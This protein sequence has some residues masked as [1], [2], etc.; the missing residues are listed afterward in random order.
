[1][2]IIPIMQYH[3][4]I[5]VAKFFIGILENL[6]HHVSYV[7]IHKGFDQEWKNITFQ[8]INKTGPN[9][10]RAPVFHFFRTL[11]ITMYICT[12]Q[13]SKQKV[14]QDGSNGY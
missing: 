11:Q 1:M 7:L 3:N 5:A 14:G 2:A 10:P 13:H 4:D 9:L 6:D 12:A 8:K